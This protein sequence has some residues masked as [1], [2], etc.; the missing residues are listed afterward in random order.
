MGDNNADLNLGL[1]TRYDAIRNCKFGILCI[2]DWL[3]WQLKFPSFE[4]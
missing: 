3:V 4:I 1:S 2:E